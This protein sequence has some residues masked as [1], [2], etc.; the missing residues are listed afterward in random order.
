[1]GRIVWYRNPKTTQSIVFLS[2]ATHAYFLSISLSLSLS[3]SLSSVLPFSCL[4]E[5]QLYIISYHQKS[6]KIN[7]YLDCFAPDIYLA[8][9]IVATIH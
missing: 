5:V 8:H 7:C 1:M 6:F 2:F 4:I 3:L 9:F